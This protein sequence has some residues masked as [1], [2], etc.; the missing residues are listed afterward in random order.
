[1]II[2]FYWSVAGFADSPGEPCEDGMVE[3]GHTMFKW[4]K[5]RSGKSPVFLWGHSLG[6]GYV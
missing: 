3:D 2:I 4:I 6:S 5:E 1:M